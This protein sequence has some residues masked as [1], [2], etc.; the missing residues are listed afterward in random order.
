[1]HYEDITKMITYC[2]NKTRAFAIFCVNGM[3]KR[4]V[5]GNS[6]FFILWFT[7]VLPDR[8]RALKCFF[9]VILSIANNCYDFLFVSLAKKYYIR[10]SELVS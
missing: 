6:L 4:G 10:R 8:D 9:F 3:G 7:V 2:W 5:E 1:M